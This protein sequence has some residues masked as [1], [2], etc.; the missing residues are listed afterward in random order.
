LRIS[1]SKV[2]RGSIYVKRDDQRNDPKWS[3]AHSTHILF[4]PPE[5]QLSVIIQ[6]GRM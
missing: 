6:E 2:D 1:L 5:N 3:T 4:I